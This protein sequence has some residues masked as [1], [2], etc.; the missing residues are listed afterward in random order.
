MIV[1]KSHAR[2]LVKANL[3][4]LEELRKACD[5]IP[6]T[7]K[8]SHWLKAHIKIYDSYFGGDNL[9][10]HTEVHH[11]RT[12]KLQKISRHYLW[13][14]DDGSADIALLV[15]NPRKCE[16]YI[17]IL[18]LHIS[19]H[20][21]MRITADQLNMKD[22]VNLLGR[23]AE[24]LFDNY[25]WPVGKEICVYDDEGMYALVKDKDE[26]TGI[27]TIVVKTFIRGD[28]LDMGSEH[29]KI[30]SELKDGE[31]II[32]PTLEEKEA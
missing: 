6:A 27:E 25:V 22:A 7:G 30:Y 19:Q 15:L 11:P 10:Q 3:R 5:V 32:H 17:D 9:L 29:E 26:E 16:F 13:F 21:L 14:K 28:K 24:L 20:A 2:A 4:K 23:N 18:P 8:A 31:F 12:K 1:N